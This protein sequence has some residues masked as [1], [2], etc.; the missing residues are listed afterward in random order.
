MSEEKPGA[1]KRQGSMYMKHPQKANLHPD[2][3]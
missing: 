1:K 2:K 3:K